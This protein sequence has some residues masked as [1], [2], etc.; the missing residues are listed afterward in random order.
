[1]RTVKKQ[2]AK[3]ENIVTNHVLDGGSV[4]RRTSPSAGQ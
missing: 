1:M 2:V 3:V 4:L